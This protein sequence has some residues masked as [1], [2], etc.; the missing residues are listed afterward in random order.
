MD[1]IPNAQEVAAAAFHH[2]RPNATAP[3]AILLAITPVPQATW[4]LDS[5]EAVV[6]ETLN[7]AKIRAVDPHT[8]RDVGQVLPALY[9]AHNL[10]HD[11]ISLGTGTAADP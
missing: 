9:F 3:Q 4:D 5:L 7:L 10:A 1:V 8:L 6:L 11:T 2:D